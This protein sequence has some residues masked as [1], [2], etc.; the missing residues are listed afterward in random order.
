MPSLPRLAIAAPAGH[1]CPGWPA[2]A[3]AAPAGQRMPSL[4]RCDVT[5]PSLPRLA[6]ACHRCPGW[7]SH[8][9]RCPGWPAHAPAGQRWHRGALAGPG[10][11]GCRARDPCSTPRS[12][13]ST[14]ETPTKNR[15]N[16]KNRK[17][18]SCYI[19]KS[20]FDIRR[21]KTLHSLPRK[22]AWGFPCPFAARLRVPGARTINTP[23]P[24]LNVK[25]VAK[26]ARSEATVENSEHTGL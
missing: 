8:R 23:G 14:L 5:P 26:G 18:A 22:A 9:H 25:G 2:H 15:K 13:K 12:P 6:S 11:G 21:G 3:I 20:V 19:P 1:R 4:P 16:R 24:F 10:F 17:N 7:P